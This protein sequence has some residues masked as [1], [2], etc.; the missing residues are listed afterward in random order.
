[1]KKIIIYTF[2]ALFLVSIVGCEEWLDVNQNPNDLTISTPELV[3]TGAAKLYGE[4]QF[5]GSGF[6]LFGVWMGY[7][8]HCGGWSGWHE[9][10]SYQ[11]TSSQ[12]TGFWNP[13]TNILK[14]TK[15]VKDHSMKEGNWGLVGAS[16][17]IEAGTYERI[18]DTYGDVPCFS[19][20]GG[21]EGVTNPV[22]DDAQEIYEDL[23][24]QL[25]SAVWYLNEA[26]DGH[27]DIDAGADPLF[28]GNKTKWIQYANVLKMRLLLKQADMSGRD[29]YISA[30]WSFDDAGFPTEVTMNPGYISGSSGK[31]NPLYE[32]YYKNYK[33]DWTSGHTQ[34]GMNVFLQHLY[35]E[36]NDPRMMMCF[37]QGKYSDDWSHGL[38]LG[39]NGAPEDHYG[40]VAGEACLIGAGI[41]GKNDDDSQV[42]S[43]PEIKFMMAEAVARGYTIPGVTATAEELWE[44]GIE[45][46][47]YYYGNRADWNSGDISDT[48]AYYMNEIELHSELGWDAGNPIKSIIYQKY[49]A[50]LGLYHYQAWTDYR[51]TGYPDPY[52]KNAVDYSM[53]SYYYI[54]VKDQVPVRMLYVQDEL[55]LNPVNVNSAIDKTGYP[56]NDQ[57]IMDARIFWDV[58]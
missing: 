31:M 54:T 51:R 15:Y 29:S 21:M 58:N 57:F 13:Y 18:I 33:D 2:L 12:Y 34:Y 30:N 48:L 25:D 36:G 46:S 38:Q 20:T 41:A 23:V 35:Q 40:G 44:E 3:F 55:D 37:I 6:S 27:V 50:G 14:S 11:M 39:I 28:G 10:H 8:G 9:V 56:Y 42:M 17:V 45:A 16:K 22:Y 19:A 26:I 52:D 1:M 43:E 32:S 4:R 49:L 7:F 53:I 24:V 5:M 47:F